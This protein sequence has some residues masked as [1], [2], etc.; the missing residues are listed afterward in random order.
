MIKEVQVTKYQ[1]ASGEIFDS[2]EEAIKDDT[3]ASFRDWYIN[4]K[5]ERT[6]ALHVDNSSVSVNVIFKWLWKHRIFIS[7]LLTVA[8]YEEERYA[9]DFEEDEANR[10][11]KAMETAK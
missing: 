3:A 5:G 1:N 6:N 4:V 10:K 2:I 11:I 7:E 9:R 8:C